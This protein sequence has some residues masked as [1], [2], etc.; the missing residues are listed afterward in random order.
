MVIPRSA[1]QSSFFLRSGQRLGTLFAL[2]FLLTYVSPSA[3]GQAVSV[4]T[5]HNDNSRTGQNTNETVLTPANVNSSNFGRLFSYPVDGQVY[6][7]PLY[8]PGVAIPGQGTHNVVFVATQHDSVYAFDADSNTGSAAGLIWHVSFG[9]SAATPNN[10]FGNRYG[11]YHDI[12]PEVGI[13]STPVIDLASG[14]MYVD[15]FTHEGSAYFHRIHALN[16]TNGV[17]LSFSPVVVKASIPGAGV[18]S[19]NGVLTFNPQQTLQR[20]ALTLSGGILYV[21]YSG[22]ADTDPYHGWVLGFLARTLQP[23]TNYVFNTTPNATVASD[24]GNAGEGGIWMSGNGPSVDANGNLYFEVGN[25]SYNANV[26]G[27][28]EYGDSFIKLS[29]GNG[30]AVADYFTPFNQASLASSDTD[31]G[32]GG[33]MLLPDSA[34]TAAHPHLMVGC[35]KEGK[36]YLLDRDNLGHYN[37][38]GDSQILQEI[39]NAVGG[40]WSSGAYFN[41]LIYYQGQNDVLKSFSIS[42]G[43]LGWTPASKSTTSFGWPGATPSISANGTNNAI[44][45][46]LQSDG[47]PTGPA[48]L[49]AYSAYNL[50][51]ELY[52]SSM[53]GS[54]DVPGGAI[55]FTVPT[56]ANGKVYVGAQSALAVFGNGTFVNPPTISPAAGLFTNSVS[57]SLSDTTSGTTVYYTLDNSTPTTSSTAYSGPFLLT[58]TTAIKAMAVKTGAVPSLVVGAILINSTSSQ[59]SP[60]FVKQEFYPGA[61]RT[62]L[63][64]PSFT[65]APS[66]IHYPSSFETPAG[67]GVNYA[68]RVSGLFTAAQTANYVFFVASD[69]DSDLFLSTDNTAL[70]KHLIAQETLWSSSREWL[71]SGGGSV[72]ASK[73]SDKFTGTK[74]PGGNTIHLT[75]GTQYYLEADHHQGGGGDDLAVTFKLSTDTDPANGTA[76]RLTTGVISSPAFNNAYVTVTSPPVDNMVPPGSTAT[77]S[78]TAVSGYLG[79]TS[80]APGPAVSYQW[81]AAPGGSSSFTNIPNATGSSYT[82]P[83][84]TVQQNGMQFQVVVTTA[85]NSTTSSI[86]SLT[87]GTP[88]VAVLTYHDDVARTGQN[89]NETVLTLANVN[90]T[91]FGQLFNYPVDG[92][93]YAQPLVMTNVNVPGNGVHNVLYIATQHDTVYAFDADSNSGTNANP[94]WKVSFLSPAAGI[95]SVPNGDVNTGDIVPEIGVTSTPVIDPVSNTI[96]VEAKTKEVVSGVNHYVQRLHALDLGT[97]AEKLSGPVVIAN[98]IYNNGNYTYV[99]GPS[100][101]GTG[102]G[103]VGGVVHFNALRQMNRPGLLLN[104]GTV[105]LAFASHGDNGPYHGWVLGYDAQTLALTGVY[106]ANPNGSDAGV[107]ESGNGPA[108]DASGNIYVETGNGTFSPPLNLGDSVLKLYTTNGLTLADYFTP[109]DQANLNSG[110]TDL[111]SGGAVVLPDSLGSALH[112]RLLLAGSKSGTIYLLDRDNLGKFNA[113]GDTQIVQA[114]RG[115]AGG[116]WST[117]AY[118]NNTLYYGGSGDALKAFRIANA[119]ISGTP[120]S[121]APSGFGFPGATPSVSA[122]GTS[123]AIV[124]AVQ[125]DGYNS[126]G[127]SVLHAYNATNLAQELYNSSMAG[128]R[129]ALGGA[130][131]FT[132]PTVANGKVYVG[133]QYLVSVF[134]NASAFVASP[135]FT[136]NGGPFTNSVMV[137]LNDTTAGASIYYTLDDSIP[138]TNSILYKAPFQVTNSL[139]VKA[140]AFK[141]GSVPSGVSSATFINSKDLGNGIGLTGDYYSNQLMT[142]SNPPTL[143]RIDPTINFNW[144]NNSPD[145]SI[146][147]TDYTVRWIGSVQPQFNETYTFYTTT[148]DGVRLWVNNQSVP[149]I[150]KWIDQAPTEWSGSIPLVAGQRYNIRMDYYQ[151]QG[152]AVAY[153]SWSSPSTTKIIIP[154]TQLYST[155]N[156]PPSVSLVNPTNSAVFLTGSPVQISA[157]ASEPGGIISQ[158]T[159]YANA[160]ALGSAT[161]SPYTLAVSNLAAG[162]YSLS[163]RATDAAGIVSTSAPVNISV[164]TSFPPLAAFVGTPSSGYEPLTVSFTDNSTGT[165]TNRFWDW[166]DGATTNTSATSLAHIYNSPGTNTVKLTVSG[167]G[168]TNTL[169]DSNYIVV[170]NLPPVGLSIKMLTNQAQLTWTLGTLQ[171]AAQATGPYTNITATSPYTLTPTGAAQFF[172]VKV[173]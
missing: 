78:V 169:V 31:L 26:S 120:T 155:N 45:W 160:T 140:K 152:G 132:V 6:A 137:T 163:A 156:P 21:A 17:E 69:D 79:D 13:T 11:P 1:L 44:A 58:N 171:S 96:Y 88:Q 151:N 100:V 173:R 108:A 75:A 85:G 29:S 38:T 105:Y 86:A 166:G 55:K 16:I 101:A 164:V 37:T 127:P 43:L 32:S 3:R 35:G 172:R 36:I 167:P 70:N 170:S 51:Q 157:N 162:S 144:N 106:N 161:N 99:S 48:I 28:T 116:M 77:F 68:E 134:G 41:N 73:R 62:D 76:P 4:L 10:D 124:W 65:T 54:R 42:A 142:F 40:T 136:P 104:N 158:V 47:Y 109:F 84:L 71:S 81:Q 150:D 92:Y 25:G 148:D 93:V 46:V 56:I 107:W 118:F 18:G 20:P 67:Q 74:W 14:T 80:G 143:I 159:F 87:V 98:T 27:G 2:A 168:G 89:T 147:Q 95:T 131:K 133:A 149:L 82:T 5:Y 57:V 12:D 23:L 94:L 115:Q 102:D 139:A 146:T 33:P 60:G 7:Q 117:A 97:G 22:F 61:V 113:A 30:L 19:T 90:T 34:G 8:V 125:S 15:A 112:P 63:E 39:T 64:N 91:T 119:T 154:Q 110:D 66:F 103:T 111:G 135:T 130:V 49:H 53:A 123:N 138:T 128:T 141:T 83:T 145:P 126:S 52:N 122:N 24:G 9:T 129:D 121:Q 165:I 59:L 114:I 153:L 72:V 50:A